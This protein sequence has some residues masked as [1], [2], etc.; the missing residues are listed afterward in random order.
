MNVAIISLLLYEAYTWKT[1]SLL[2]LVTFVDISI[3]PIV[4]INR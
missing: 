1:G 4:W 2:L 3:N